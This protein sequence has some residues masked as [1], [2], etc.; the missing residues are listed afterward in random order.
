MFGKLFRK[1]KKRTEAE[2]DDKALSSRT[3][4]NLAGPTDAEGS[5]PPRL[6]ANGDTITK[7][8]SLPERHTSSGRS[9][10]CCLPKNE[11]CTPDWEPLSVAEL[12]VHRELQES[13]GREALSVIPDEVIVCF[14]RSCAHNENWMSVASSRLS[15]IIEWRAK[16]RCSEL[17]VSPPPERDLF[18]EMHKAGPVGRDA[19][20]RP[21]VFERLTST[22]ASP[23]HAKFDQHTIVQHLIYGLEA[24]QVLCRAT[25]H[26]CCKRLYSVVWIV[27]AQGVGP[28]HL[29]MLSLAHQVATG[30]PEIVKGLYVINVPLLLRSAWTLFLRCLISPRFSAKVTLLGGQVEY[31]RVFA[32]LGIVFDVSI[33]DGLEL[34]WSRTMARIAPGGVVP[35]TFVPFDETI[36]LMRAD[37]FG[38][39]RGRHAQTFS[40]KGPAHPAVKIEDAAVSQSTNPSS[41]GLSNSWDKRFP[42]LQVLQVEPVGGGIRGTFE[43]NA[44]EPVRIEGEEFVGSALILIKPPKPSDDPY[45]SERLFDGRE[46]KL[47]L[48]VQGQFKRVPSGVVCF[49][50]EFAPTVQLGL[51]S[52]GLVKVLLSYMHK[53][54]PGLHASFGSKDGAE[55]PHI[56]MPLWSSADRL[57]VTPNGG[58]PPELGQPILETDQARH[59]RYVNGIATLAPPGGWDTEKIYTFSFCTDYMDL[60]AW[61]LSG[62]PMMR[63]L[64]LGAFVG[65]TAIRLVVYS[66]S[67]GQSKHLRTENRYSI[68]LSIRNRA[69]RRDEPAAEALWGDPV[70][71]QKGAERAAFGEDEEEDEGEDEG[72]GEDATAGRV[73]EEGEDGEVEDESEK[74]P[75]LRVSPTR[76]QSKKLNAKKLAAQASLAPPSRPLPPANGTPNVDA[77]ELFWGDSLCPACIDIW[78]ASTK[79]PAHHR[80]RRRRRLYVIKLDD[81]SSM[82]RTYHDIQKWLPPFS[83]SPPRWSSRLSSTERQR[84]VICWT[85][86]CAARGP[87]GIKAANCDDT[88][89]ASPMAS[90]VSNACINSP[91]LLAEPLN[92]HI[93][94]SPES[95]ATAGGMEDESVGESSRFAGSSI[96]SAF[97]VES[98][99]TDSITNL[100]PGFGSCTA[101]GGF[102]NTF[103]QP[104]SSH[105]SSRS[106]RDAKSRSTASKGLGTPRACPAAFPARSPHAAELRRG[107]DE[108][109]SRFLHS[110]SSSLSSSHLRDPSTL[111]EGSVARCASESHWLEEWAQL[112]E[113]RLAFHGARVRSRREPPTLV[114]YLAELLSVEEVPSELAPLKEMQVIGISTVGRIYYF[115]AGDREQCARWMDS[116]IAQSSQ[117]RA[118]NAYYSSIKGVHAVPPTPSQHEVE[119]D[120]ES[121]DPSIA[122]MHNSS[123]WRCGKRRIL[124]CRRMLLPVSADSQPHPCII[125]EN[126]LRMSFA[127]TAA[128][129]EGS[130]TNATL[131]PFLDATCLL[132]FCSLF[133]LSESEQLAYLLNLYHLMTQHAYLVL[134]PPASTQQWLTLYNL[135]AYQTADDVFSLAELEH[136]ILRAGMSSPH[137]FPSKFSTPKS[138]F[139]LALARR[140]WRL[141]FALNSGSVSIPSGVPIYLPHEIHEQLEHTA[142]RFIRNTVQVQLLADRSGIIVVLPKVMLWYQRDFGRGT[143]LDCVR[144]AVLYLPERQTKLLELALAVS[145]SGSDPLPL[146]ITYSTYEFRCGVL[147]RVETSPNDSSQAEAVDC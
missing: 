130:E 102:G 122:F 112:S 4:R 142:A 127:V 133:T 22:S 128:L 113:T 79:S 139:A 27:D 37:W 46:R 125:V 71:K 70:L 90:P 40:L 91:V 16:W 120:V 99:Y 54:L 123:R 18:E 60:P 43:L 3:R 41:D 23:L 87:K 20:Q 61:K 33:N 12:R 132:R 66:S 28:E 115:S 24:A 1:R 93:P 121:S 2:K 86:L 145:P 97:S 77:C 68:S 48:Q 75:S 65:D 80:Q 84:R 92:E 98:N 10:R 78:L 140:D 110:L 100:M 39:T 38:Q 81:G 30:Y 51:V 106:K 14:L 50:A 25:S 35:P 82:L 6:W 42:M 62:L 108:P 104:G 116:I 109:G 144:A 146:T 101:A 74:P 11:L 44:R 96:D 9:H 52:R 56:T 15:A 26:S 111:L 85:L 138:S 8:N 53:K 49:G 88:A 114:I 141:N 107:N 47:E 89:S 57:V 64:D 119:P 95:V 5:L 17:L 124:N 63:D 69:M 29:Y 19:D 117:I 103:S 105:I 137:N 45:Y 126:A 134:G 36:M 72:E 7:V 21:V 67:A 58:T 32:D 143:A 83:S 34:S 73:E 55:V 76:G 147:K 135:V 118:M 31:D 136:C 94:T 13:L 131:V 129:T 59:E